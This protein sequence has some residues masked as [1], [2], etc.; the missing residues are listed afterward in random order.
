MSFCQ[1]PYGFH[2]YPHHQNPVLLHLR[3]NEH[4]FTFF[5]RDQL[6]YLPGVLFYGFLMNFEKIKLIYSVKILDFANLIYLIF[7]HFKF[8]FTQNFHLLIPLLRKYFPPHPKL[9]FHL[10]SDLRFRIQNLHLHR[11]LLKK[12][13]CHQLQ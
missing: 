12:L 10:F 6:F 7:Y 4:I 8:K 9:D 3:K 1:F 5:L 2:L 11:Y 13:P